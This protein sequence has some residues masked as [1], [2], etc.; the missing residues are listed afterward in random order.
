MQL[1]D[2]EKDILY[3]FI[4]NNELINFIYRDLGADKVERPSEHLSEKEEKAI[5]IAEKIMDKL[6]EQH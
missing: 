5:L 1:E 4:D 2:F 3:R 6:G